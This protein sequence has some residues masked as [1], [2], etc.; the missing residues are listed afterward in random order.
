MFTW[1]I[2]RTKLLINNINN[3][4]HCIIQSTN[5]TKIETK[6]I[7]IIIIIAST[8]Y[9]FMHPVDNKVF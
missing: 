9:I 3:L 8:N 6:I 2:K 7:L 4:I 1:P 5:I